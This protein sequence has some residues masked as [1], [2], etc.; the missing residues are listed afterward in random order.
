MTMG[1]TAEK[2]IRVLIIDDHPVVRMGM[3]SMLSTQPGI[4][5]QPGA[6][7]GPEAI[8]LYTRKKADVVLM[9]LRMPN[10]S[11]IETIR[12]LRSLDPQVH[13]LVVTNYETDEDICTALRDGALGYLTKDVMP[14]EMLRAIRAVSNG[15]R[16]VPPALAQRIADV[17]MR[18]A[19]TA[20]ETEILRMLATGWTNKRIGKEMRISE[21]TVRNHVNHIFSKLDVVDRTEAAIVAVQRGLVRLEDADSHRI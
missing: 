15:R 10:M 9:D 7:S 4:V 2:T 3:A 14:E 5:V 8:E 6:S 21:N 19:L 12:Q 16:H 13:I 18:P 20:R 1:Q 11:G 17:M